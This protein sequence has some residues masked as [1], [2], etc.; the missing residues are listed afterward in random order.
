MPYFEV[1]I[2]RLLED[3]DKTVR[4]IAKILYILTGHKWQHPS[5]GT[6]IFLSKSCN[7]VTECKIFTHFTCPEANQFVI[8]FLYSPARLV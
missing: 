8:L 6:N 1:S 7:F 3:A 2:R 4:Y 5:H